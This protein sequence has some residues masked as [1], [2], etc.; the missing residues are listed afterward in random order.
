MFKNLGNELLKEGKYSEAI[1]KYGLGLSFKRDSKANLLNRALC[2]MK[3]SKF[4]SC[5]RDCSK[6]LEIAELFEQGYDESRE[7]NF[8]A[9]IRRAYSRKELHEFN[10]ALYDIDQAIKLNPK[11]QEAQSLKQEIIIKI[12]FH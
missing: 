11:S 5:I 1:D 2:L 7:T 3:L 12:Q 6:V 9:L 10:D 4:K 8:K